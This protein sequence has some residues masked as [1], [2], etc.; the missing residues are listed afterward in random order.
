[1][2]SIA[3]LVGLEVAQLTQLLT[4]GVVLLVLLVV[5]RIVLKLTATIFKVGCFGILFI[6]VAVFVLQLLG[7][8]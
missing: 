2:E 6:V 5:L 8:F 4:L 7:T 1:M 3:Q